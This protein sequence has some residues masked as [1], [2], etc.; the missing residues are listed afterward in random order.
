MPELN[1]HS[2]PGLVN[3]QVINVYATVVNKVLIDVSS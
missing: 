3:G 1:T 2:C